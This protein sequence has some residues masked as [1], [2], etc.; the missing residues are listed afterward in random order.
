LADKPDVEIA[1]IA[2]GGLHRASAQFEKA[3]AQVTTAA[4]PD[5]GD[6]IDLSTAAVA[7]LTA[8]NDF[9]ANLAAVRVGDEMERTAIQL[10]G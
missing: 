10:M 9:S 2:L 5:K 8:R 6:T 1:S 4:I 7:M 3:A